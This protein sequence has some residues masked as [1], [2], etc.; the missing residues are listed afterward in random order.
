ML[1]PEHIWCHSAAMQDRLVEW[2]GSPP[3]IDVGGRVDSFTYQCQ[4]KPDAACLAHVSCQ[5]L[6]ILAVELQAQ[7]IGQ[8]HLT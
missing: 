2:L 5:Q 8:A 1:H 4:V 3:H 7:S 6:V